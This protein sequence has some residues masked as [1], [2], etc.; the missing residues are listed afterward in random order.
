M[1]YS[2]WQYRCSCGAPTPLG[3]HS[4]G[5]AMAQLS[6]SQDSKGKPL[7][8]VLGELVNGT[9]L[10]SVEGGLF[11]PSGSLS[12]ELQEIIGGYTIVPQGSEVVLQ[13]QGTLPKIALANIGPFNPVTTALLEL[14]HKHCLR[15]TEL[16][17]ITPN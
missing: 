9:M 1:C 4:T 2:Q 10:Y 3:S 12:S 6:R 8:L 5:S 15:H 7:G 16:V 17:R 11:G 14:L 13:L